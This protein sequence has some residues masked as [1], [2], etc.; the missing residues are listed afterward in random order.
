MHHHY[1]PTAHFARKLSHLKKVDTDG[2]RRIQKTISRLLLH[3][4]DADGRMVGLYDGRLKKYV[5]RG[6]FRIIYYWCRLC[7]RENQR[8]HCLIPDNSVIFFDIYHKK[9]KKRIKKNSTQKGDYAT[10]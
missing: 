10:F 9:D 4:E 6:D 5:G 3:P 2:Y 8:Q 1:Q 7:H